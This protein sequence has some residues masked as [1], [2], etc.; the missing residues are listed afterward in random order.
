[1]HLG[2]G[3]GLGWDDE[4][5]E[6]DEAFQSFLFYFPLK[7]GVMVA[8]EATGMRYVLG[9]R[10]RRV[11]GEERGGAATGMRYGLGRGYG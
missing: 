6:R 11:T 9:R 10:Y 1:L 7:R 8:R 4:R 2:G 3:I 5:D